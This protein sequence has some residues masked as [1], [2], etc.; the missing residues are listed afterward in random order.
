[1]YQEDTS[2]WSYLKNVVLTNI[3]KIAEKSLLQNSHIIHPVTN[4][5]SSPCRSLFIHPTSILSLSPLLALV[6]HFIWCRC[7]LRSWVTFSMWTQVSLVR[8]KYPRIPFSYDSTK[9]NTSLFICAAFDVTCSCAFI[10]SNTTRVALA[11]ASLCPVRLYSVSQFWNAVAWGINIDSNNHCTIILNVGCCQWSS[12]FLLVHS[13]KA[14]ARYHF[15]QRGQRINSP[16]VYQRRQLPSGRSV[17]QLA[18]LPTHT[19]CP[20]ENISTSKHASCQ[21]IIIS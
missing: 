19:I 16:N 12:G 2:V 20:M 5:N 11:N 10:S 15:L 3:Q 18:S 6:T 4:E 8:L 21:V 7:L 1:M 13:H 14:E 9:S 17:V